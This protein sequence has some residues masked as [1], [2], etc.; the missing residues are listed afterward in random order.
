MLGKSVVQLHLKEFGAHLYI[1][2]YIKIIIKIII[3][4]II[5][6]ITYGFYFFRWRGGVIDYCKLHCVCEWW[7]FQF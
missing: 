1:I 3:I 2:G 6:I 5:I 7:L 4:I